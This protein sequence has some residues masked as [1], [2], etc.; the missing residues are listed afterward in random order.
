MEVAGGYADRRA[1]YR[2]LQCHAWRDP[3]RGSEKP[4]REEPARALEALR[5][6]V[7]LRGEPARQTGVS[8]DCDGGREDVHTGARD[9]GRRPSAYLVA[10]RGEGARG[11]L[12][13]GSR[14]THVRRAAADPT[15]G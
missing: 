15:V 13:A 2:A 6:M 9:H 14:G 12:G 4:D 7:C 8:R 11:V 3:Y 10:L 1:V 5:R